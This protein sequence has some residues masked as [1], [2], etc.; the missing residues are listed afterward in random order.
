MQ[1][2]E[3]KS[4]IALRSRILSTPQGGWGKCSCFAKKDAFQN[5]DFSCLNC[6]LEQ[7]KINAARFLRFFEC[8]PTRNWVSKVNLS[9]FQLKT[10]F[11]SHSSLQSP[12]SVSFGLRLS[13]FGCK[14]SRVALGM[15]M[16]KFVLAGLV[17]ESKTSW[18]HDHAYILSCKH[19]KHDP[20]PIRN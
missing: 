20:R 12:L 9:S 6:Q 5:M 8:R 16:F 1:T 2:A 13:L 17:R 10:F 11:K 18:R 19:D 14:V 15:R 3:T 7:K 4:W